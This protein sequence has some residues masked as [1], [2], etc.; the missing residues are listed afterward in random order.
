MSDTVYENANE[1]DRIIQAL[2]RV[3]AQGRKFQHDESGSRESLIEATRDLLTAAERPVESLLWSIWA[4][5]TR[6]VAARVAIDLQIFQTTIQDGSRPKSIDE[7]AAPMKASPEVVERIARLSFSRLPEYLRSTRF[8]NP[9]DPTNGPFQFANQWDGHAFDWI[10]EHQEV[11]QAFHGFVY[12]LRAHRPSWFE[13][14]PVKERL[15]EGMDIEGSAS[16]LVD[17][18]GGTGQTLEDFR[19]HVPNYTG[20][21]VL[22]DLPK[23]IEAAQKQGLDTRISLQSHDFFTPQP[24]KGARAYFIRSVLHDLANSFPQWNKLLTAKTLEWPDDVC[25]KILGHLKDAMKPGY[26]KILIN[27]CVVAN[28]KAAWQHVSLDIFIVTRKTPSLHPFNQS[29]GLTGLGADLIVYWL[30]EEVTRA[31]LLQ[32]GPTVKTF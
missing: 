18:G 20:K 26:S 30:T 24:I 8:Q 5:P 12:T 13:M 10:A 31:Y 23:V 14:Y 29:E 11:F 15:I 7:L 9:Q 22:Q 28:E 32:K 6:T 2:A 1:K 3:T 19:A 17:I 16:A 27:D 4:L 21:L 25:H